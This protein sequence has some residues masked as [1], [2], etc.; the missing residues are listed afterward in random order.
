MSKTTEKQV[1]VRLGLRALYYRSDHGPG[2]RVSVPTALMRYVLFPAGKAI[3]CWKGKPIPVDA[4]MR[5][6]M[7][8]FS[9]KV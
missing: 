8:A 1:C 5:P 7:P 4:F 6:G 3:Y 2:Q 9:A